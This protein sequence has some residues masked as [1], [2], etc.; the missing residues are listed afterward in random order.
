MHNTVIF[1]K[2]IASKTSKSRTLRWY[3]QSLII[4]LKFLHPT[5]YAN[6]NNKWLMRKTIPVLKSRKK[7]K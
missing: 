2:K 6:S 5:C 3:T 4:P 1:V 7:K